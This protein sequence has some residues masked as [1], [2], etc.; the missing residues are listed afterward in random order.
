MS[1]IKLNVF[2]ITLGLLLT[3]F[4]V[5]SK[6]IRS[7]IPKTFIELGYTYDIFKVLILTP[8][9]VLFVLNVYLLWK[10]LYV[11]NDT[12]YGFSQDILKVLTKIIESPYNPLTLLTRAMIELDAFIKN[13]CPS[14]DEHRTYASVFIEKICLNFFNTSVK[15]ILMMILCS[16]APQFIICSCFVVDLLFNDHFFYFY[17]TL[18]LSIFPLLFRYV[19]HSINTLIE[20]NLIML[21]S[22]MVLKIIHEDDVDEN[23]TLKDYV[24][25]TIYQWKDIVSSD[26]GEKYVCYNNFNQQILA[27]FKGDMKS[28]QASLE[29]TITLM[30]SLFTFDAY[31]SRYRNEN[32][33]LKVPF[34][35]IKYI[36]YLIGWSYLLIIQ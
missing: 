14:Y 33:L 21:D 22:I 2:L 28:A 26:D 15:R 35:I 3:L 27:R 11:K 4:I 17:K 5:Y 8:F 34:N 30:E 7:R 1:T 29:Y 10:Y 16:I 6:L 23:T 36:I 12:K 32:F 20:A 25:I 31:M 24:D 19:I 13:N 18:W 9:L